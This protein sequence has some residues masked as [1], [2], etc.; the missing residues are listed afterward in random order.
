M[1]GKSTTDPKKPKDKADS[2]LSDD[3]IRY[4]I[5]TLLYKKAK[6]SPDSRILHRKKIVEI[7][8]IPENSV[9]FN[10]NYLEEAKLIEKVDMFY[11]SEGWGG[12]R[13]TASGIDV[14]EHKE[15]NKNCFPFLNATIPI[16]IQNKI[17]L[18]N[19]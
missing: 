1:R 11:S 15:K 12:D 18:I 19:L 2:V 7:L 14:V 6:E 9:Y 3:E 5:L 17:G 4:S 13:V 10:L 8:C 16:Q